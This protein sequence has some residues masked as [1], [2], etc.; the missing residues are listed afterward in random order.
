[1]NPKTCAKPT[2]APKEPPPLGNAPWTYSNRSPKSCA[3][4]HDARTVTAKGFYSKAFSGLGQAMWPHERAR[5]PSRR[6]FSPGK[7][8]FLAVGP[9]WECH[10]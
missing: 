1:M 4:N 7:G 6:V 3:G 9:F 5:T 10:G 2:L 8:L